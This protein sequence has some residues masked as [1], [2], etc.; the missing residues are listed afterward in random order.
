MQELSN[1]DIEILLLFNSS[2]SLIADDIVT[3]LTSALTW[4]P[5]Y[6]VLIYMFVKKNKSVLDIST[7]IIFALLC[8]FLSGGIN[9][10]FIKPSVERLRPLNDINVRHLL[11]IADGVSETQYSFFSSHAANT[12]SLAIF[13][14]L[15]TRNTVLCISMVA[16]SLV[17]CWTRLYLGVHYPSDIIVG[18]SWGC[19]MG[20]LCFYLY[21]KTKNWLYSRRVVD[22]INQNENNETIVSE[23]IRD[24]GYNNTGYTTKEIII[25]PVILISIVCAVIIKAVFMP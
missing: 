7:I 20:V 1:M 24:N 9:D 5:V 15:L 17:N 2:N 18:L 10:M 25:I 11:H 14:S 16:W 19:L 13:I 4:M 3:T 8:V 23:I 12:F 22:L 21:N 6:I